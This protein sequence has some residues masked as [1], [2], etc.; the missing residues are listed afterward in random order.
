MKGVVFNLMEKYI[1]KNLGDGRYEEIM[2][3]CTLTT[4]VP[5]VGPGTYPDEDLM[6]IV[7]ETIKMGGI[8]LPETLRSF[9][10]FC[11]YKLSE[12]YPCFVSPYTHPK[13]FLKSV[14]SIIHV[15]VKKL[16][17]DAMPPAFTYFDSAPDRLVIQY[18]SGRRLCQFMEGLIEGVAGHYQ[19]PIKYEQR[20]CM[21][22]GGEVCE[23]ELTF[24]P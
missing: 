3:R 6:T 18:K 11:F 16:Y 23:F 5:F 8:P 4:K 21:L 13:P 14:E 24:L 15:E 2:E 17:E 22:D 9:G 20:T 7:A 12:K 19:S 10:R 1:E